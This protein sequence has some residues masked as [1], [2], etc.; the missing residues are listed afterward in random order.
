LTTDNR[1]DAYMQFRLFDANN[2]KTIQ[3]GSAK[4]E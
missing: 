4:Y 2:N 3:G 1:Q